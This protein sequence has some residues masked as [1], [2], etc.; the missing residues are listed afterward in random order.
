MLC[1][2]KAEIT[3]GEVQSYWR[4]ERGTFVGN[5]K[6]FGTFRRTC[7]GMKKPLASC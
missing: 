5:R 1:T 6:T 4:G 2:D 3:F 7:G